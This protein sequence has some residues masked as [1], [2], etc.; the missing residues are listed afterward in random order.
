MSGSESYI[1]ANEFEDT[2]H[3][4]LY[5]NEL[6]DILINSHALPQ[7]FHQARAEVEYLEFLPWRKRNAFI[8][9]PFNIW[10]LKNRQRAK[11]ERE[12]GAWLADTIFLLISG[13]HLYLTS[14]NK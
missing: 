9:S 12:K 3:L 11:L 13:L 1:P 10:P 2:T 7:T 6:L 5:I 4:V 8:F 14:Q